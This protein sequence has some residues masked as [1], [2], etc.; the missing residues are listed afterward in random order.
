M[1]YDAKAISRMKYYLP[2][3]EA[4]LVKNP[5][6][7]SLINGIAHI[8]KVLGLPPTLEAIDPFRFVD[9]LTEKALLERKGR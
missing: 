9:E 7:L 6:S 1:E 4:M 5:K 3:L 8:R 2:E